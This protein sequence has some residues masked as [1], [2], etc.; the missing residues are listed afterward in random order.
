MATLKPVT[1]YVVPELK[2]ELDEKG[3]DYKSSDLKPDLY[4]KLEEH[5]A[6]DEEGGD[7]SEADNSITEG[8]YAAVNYAGK[9]KRVFDTKKDAEEYA[10]GRG[11]EVKKG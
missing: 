1:D 9:V 6:S 5:Y 8:S 2:K 4:A 7:D 3:I 10:D 11:Y